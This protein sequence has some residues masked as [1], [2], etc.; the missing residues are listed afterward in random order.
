MHTPTRA[1]RVGTGALDFC[2]LRILAGRGRAWR[3]GA[4]LWLGQVASA[5]MI[6]GLEDSSWNWRGQRGQNLCGQHGQEGECGPSEGWALTE[7]MRES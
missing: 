2:C 5:G 6:T 4:L 1:A 7:G 3:E